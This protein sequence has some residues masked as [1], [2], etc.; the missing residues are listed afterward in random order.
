MGV[1]FNEALCNHIDYPLIYLGAK[2]LYNKEYQMFTFHSFN[3]AN[4]KL[5]KRI[6]KF[7]DF[8]NKKREIVTLH[9]INR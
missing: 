1:V 5:R 3:L 7:I 8:L 4:T 6:V 2:M 9:E